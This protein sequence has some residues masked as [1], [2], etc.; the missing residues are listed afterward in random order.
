MFKS[1]LK[2]VNEHHLIKPLFPSIPLIIACE[3]KHSKCYF[4]LDIEGLKCM[5]TAPETVH[6]K[7]T[8]NDGQMKDL[9]TGQLKLQQLMELKAIKVEGTFRDI[10]RLEA[11][12]SLAADHS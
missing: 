6:L 7:M 2:R 3:S 8:G 4:Q 12:L 5:E 10:L 1:L 11:I 9:L